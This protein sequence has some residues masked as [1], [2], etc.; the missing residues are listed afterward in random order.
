MKRHVLFR[1]NLRRMKFT[2]SRML[3]GNF[4]VR[5]ETPAL[6]TSPVAAGA[7]VCFSLLL[8]FLVSDAD[9]CQTKLNLIYGVT[10]LKLHDNVIARPTEFGLCVPGVTVLLHEAR[11]GLPN[12]GCSDG[13]RN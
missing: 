8:C 12:F 5:W 10:N 11:H 7:F 4:G 6:L 1:L 9:V 2:V 3:G 13:S